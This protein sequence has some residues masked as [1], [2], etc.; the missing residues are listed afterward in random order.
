VRTVETRLEG[1]GLRVGIV[2]ARFN[3]LITR[4]L[5]DGCEARL[6]ELGC[7]SIDLMWVPGAFEIPLAAQGAARTGSYDVLVALGAVVRGE[8]PHFDYVCRAATDGVR[9]VSLE[10]GLPI[11][12]GVLTVETVE[13]AL[14][15]AAKPGEA[16]SN[17]GAEAAEVAVEM[18]RL[19]AGLDG[20]PHG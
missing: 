7:A 6:R 3:H 14:A 13:Q 16:G 18:A 11:A 15:R 19:L 4:R 9:Q 17:K 12:F 8:T 10:S 1:A 5:V 20:R 2:A